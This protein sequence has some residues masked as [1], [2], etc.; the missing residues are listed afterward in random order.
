MRGDVCRE[1]INHLDDGELAC[2]HA[3]QDVKDWFESLKLPMELL[4]FMQ[5]NW[6]QE[7]GQL[8]H[9]SIL[10]SRNLKDDDFSARL[11]EA[12]FLLIGAA[13]NG[14][15]LVVDFGKG[16]CSPGFITHEEWDQES[17]PRKFFEPIARSLESLLYRIAEKKYIPTDYYAAK[18]FNE[19]LREEERA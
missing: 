9:L 17:D 2:G 4:R 11:A 19:F 18:P 16:V 13:P 6:P 1:L 3:P 8:A 12:G 5:W 14:D 15:W 10:S 7:D